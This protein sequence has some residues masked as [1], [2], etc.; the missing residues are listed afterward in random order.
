M[1]FELLVK[2][3]NRM[4]STYRYEACYQCKLPERDKSICAAWVME[5]PNES[6]E[7]IKNWSE[8]HPAKTNKEKF[9]EVF[10][11]VKLYPD[12]WEEPYE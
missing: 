12:W 2:E 4:C 8:T 10:G 6:I 11:N 5:H 7:L 9:I 3:F 1:D